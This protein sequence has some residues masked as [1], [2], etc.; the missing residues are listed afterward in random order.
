[1]NFIA[2]FSELS[3]DD[4][5]TVGGKAA[6]LGEM[7]NAKLPV[8][9]GFVVTAGAFKSF[10]D[11]T[12]LKKQIFP[13][14][15]N[16][17]VEDNA[18]LQ[19]ASQKIGELIIKTQMPK[20]IASAITEAYD[21]LDI[22]EEIVKKAGAEA[23]SIVKTGRDL[24]L[25]AVRSSATAEDLP[26]ASF[27]GQ[28]ETFLNI[29]GSHPLLNAV[30]KCWASL[31]T[32]RAIYYRVKNNF[33][34]EKVLIAVAVQKMV[35]SDKAGV[36]FSMNPTTNNEQEILIEGAFGLGEAVVSGALTPDE[37]LIDKETEETKSI[38]LGNKEWM[39]TLDPSFGKTV[40]KTLPPGKREEQV[41]NDHEISVLAQLAKRIE[42]H[43]GKPQDMEWAIEGQKI[44]ITQSRPVTTIEKIKEKTGQGEEHE[45][46]AYKEPIVTGIPASPGVGT[47][48]VKIVR[49]IG[50][51]N[52]MEKGDILVAEMTNPDYVSAMEKSAAI[53]TDRGGATCFAEDTKILTDKGFMSIKDACDNYEDILVPS[54][55]RETMKIEWKPVIAAMKRK[56]SAIEISMSQTGNMKNNC[57]R[58]TPDHKMITFENRELTDRKISEVLDKN[59]MLL[60][61]QKLPSLNESSGLKLKR[62]YLL[63]AL[64]TD[65][66]VSVNNRRGG[67]TFVQKPTEEKQKFIESVTTFM[68]DLYEKDVKIYP[69]PLSGGI[70]RGRPIN[71]LANAYC[72]HSKQ[73]A[74][75]IQEQKQTLV[76]ELLHSDELFAMHFLAG[77]IDGDGSYNH[78]SSRINIYVGK[79]KLIDAVIVSCLRLGIVPQVTAN[80]T[81]HNVQ[82]VERIPELLKY[83]RRVKGDFNRKTNGTRLFSAKQLL[84]DVIDNV[85]YMGRIKP[86]V[87]NNLLLDSEKIRTQI[88]PKCNAE[89]KNALTKILDSDVRMIRTIFDR[90]IGEIDVYNITVADN[91]NYIAFTDRYTPVIVSNCHAAIVGREMGIPVIVGTKNATQVLKEGEIIT[92]DA[93]AGKVYE[94][95]LNIKHEEKK[96]SYSAQQELETATEV[97]VIVDLPQF[98]HTAAET[99]ADG[100]GLLR[101]EMMLMSTRA[102]PAYLIR[103]GREDEI[104]NA[105]VEGI[106]TIAKAFEGKPVWYRTSDIR[107]DEYRDLEGGDEEPEEDNPMMGYHGI[108]RGMAE[109]DLL[110]AEFE[111]IKKVHDMGFTIV[112]VMLSLVTHL[113]Q[114]TGSKELLREVGLEPQENID[115]GVMV[116]TPAAVQ[117][118]EEICE[119]GIDFI[120]F[121]TN[122]LTQFTLALDR[123]NENVAPLY[124]E[125]HPAVM[126]Q[127]KHVIDVC[128]QYNVETSICGQAGSDP[129]MAEFLVKAGIDSISANADAVHKIRTIVAKAEKKILL[130]V[131]RKDVEHRNH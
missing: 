109:K 24:P 119:E 33:P 117:I 66:H 28:Q 82:I 51:L 41:L 129:E 57:L 123:N 47:G 86:Y 7:Y 103:N 79:P 20:N 116:E 67:I 99:G 56:A 53:V 30:Q 10:L 89:T 105:L 97:K 122:D 13:L 49:E 88:L 113:D 104:I 95:E 2:W 22:D 26:E 50:D 130:D 131:A 80:R 73:A 110:R 126:R 98:A 102:H 114:V 48:P 15:K 92:V 96:E 6:N 5:P 54:M 127:I 4:V 11:S 64:M 23:L 124:D 40:K 62:A 17:D 9:P 3:K 68:N 120:S 58:L 81:I 100:V 84:S 61:A 75:Q 72:W 112:G 63:G 108:R 77:V 128:R 18:K 43:Y 1:M 65:G 87:R 12:G 16:L 38:K 19:E 71:G 36:M 70:I 91:H 94:G 32:A 29:K 35:N 8:P 52:K 14:L 46:E 25:V 76:S 90:E 85:N 78:E 39:L 111:A 31:Y 115:F 44:Y 74:M 121:G 37:Y 34:H 21:N 45:E 118:I 125:M 60:I 55:N 69:K 106:S 59:E 107:T 93:T 27:A 42:H 101:S 83:T